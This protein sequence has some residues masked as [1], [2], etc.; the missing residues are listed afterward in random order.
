MPMSLALTLGNRL[1]G[2]VA[3]NGGMCSNGCVRMRESCIDGSSMY[4]KIFTDGVVS[5]PE[6]RT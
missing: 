6:R 3:M 2:I 5:T 4:S 1:K